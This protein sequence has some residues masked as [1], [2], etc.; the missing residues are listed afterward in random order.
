M[1]PFMKFPLY[2]IKINEDFFWIEEGNELAMILDRGWSKSVITETVM[3]QSGK[4][5]QITKEEY[6]H[7]V[8]LADEYSANK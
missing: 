8:D 4:E 5:R 6:N 3:D 7:L 2:R 1:A